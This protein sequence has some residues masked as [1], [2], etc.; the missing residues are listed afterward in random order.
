MYDYGARFYDPTVARWWSVDPMAEKY[1]SYSPYNYV[2]NNPIIKIDPN[3]MWDDWYT[4]QDGTL[5]YDKKVES[6][7]DLKDGQTYVGK[8]AIGSDKDGK[9][10]YG[11][12]YGKTHSS[13]SLNEVKV[14]SEPAYKESIAYALFGELAS[15]NADVGPYGP[16]IP[17][18][19]GFEISGSVTSVIPSIMPATYSFS[20]GF[21]STDTQIGFYGSLSAEAGVTP[22]FSTNLSV[23]AYMGTYTDLGK[24]NIKGL[25]NESNVTSL[26]VGEFGVYHSNSSKN[27]KIAGGF[28]TYGLSINLKPSF[29]ITKGSSFTVM[30]NF[31][32]K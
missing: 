10:V 7:K 20:L 3:G 30:P 32:I 18:I 25:S 14:T 15:G 9:T 8:T 1:D 23:K 28:E 11:D 31:L 21:A 22:P 12:Q 5:K 2:R 16:Y 27:G 24:T 26:N 17:D 4:E 19:V 29:G 6:Q 13:V